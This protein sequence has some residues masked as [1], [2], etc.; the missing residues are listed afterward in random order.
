MS[1]FSPT[2]L[3]EGEGGAIG[4]L[5][6]TVEEQ[7]NLSVE[8]GSDIAKTLGELCEN[9]TQLRSFLGPEIQAKLLKIQD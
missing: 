3:D 8:K 1:L 4:D 9:A 6:I 2:L 7:M 5:C